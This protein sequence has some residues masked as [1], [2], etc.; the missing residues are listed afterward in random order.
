ML[1]CLPAGL[2][3]A[4]GSAWSALVPASRGKVSFDYRLRRF[5][6]CQGAPWQ[7]A[8]V[9]WR[10]IFDADERLALLAPHMRREVA[11]IDPL[12]P[13]RSHFADVQ[14]C[15]PLDQALYV[16][17]KTWLADD[18]LVKVD[19][20]AMANSLES[21][22]PFLDS[23]L[24]EFAASLPA[25]LKL[26]GAAGKRVLK[27]SQRARLPRAVLD[28]RKR[29]FNAPVAHWTT[30]I[31][32]LLQGDVAQGMIDGGAVAALRAEHDA[33]RRDNSHRLYGLASLHVWLGRLRA[34][35]AAAPSGR[36][37]V[38]GAA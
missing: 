33:R 27:R 14:D 24:V 13:F 26:A 15:D 20:A 23:D 9:G 31:G 10:M 16:D 34:A 11:T 7:D 36:P 21:R 4:A 2:L 32:D 37:A 19:R 22:A 25:E 8:H 29:G 38:P 3:R 6:A 12:A 17:T 18:I 30:A 28:R 35:P 1:D 5:L